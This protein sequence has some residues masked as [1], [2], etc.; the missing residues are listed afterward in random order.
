MTGGLAWVLAVAMVL[1]ACSSLQPAMT[2]DGERLPKGAR[3]APADGSLKTVQEAL[4]DQLKAWQGTPYRLGGSSRQGVDCSAFTQ[5]TLAQRLSLNLPR[6]TEQQADVGFDVA[7]EAMQPGDLVFFRTGRRSN[8]VGIYLGSR[9]FL[10]ASTSEGVTL[11]SLDE[12][13]WKRHYWTARRV[14]F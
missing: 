7:Q 12:A 11:N 8:H 6:T 2:L 1:P 5:I 13:Y 9:W 4:L 3:I 14:L 10:H